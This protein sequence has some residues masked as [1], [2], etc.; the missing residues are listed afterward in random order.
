TGGGAEGL[1]GSFRCPMEGKEDWPAR[2]SVSMVRGHGGLHGRQGGAGIYEGSRTAGPA[3][4]NRLYE[5][6]EP[7]GGRRVSGGYYPRSSYRGC[8]IPRGAGRLV[9]R[10]QPNRYQH[11]SG[12]HLGKSAASQRGA[13]LR[14]FPHIDRRSESFH[15]R[16]FSKLPRGRQATLSENEPGRNQIPRAAGCE[17]QRAHSDLAH[18][19]SGDLSDSSTEIENYPREKLMGYQK[20]LSPSN[21]FIAGAVRISP[22]FP[23]KPFGNDGLLRF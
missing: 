2:R 16:R 8:K 19:I 23:I 3:N 7:F 1:E 12:W 11:S 15:R 22:R 13:T 18:G 21:V 5:H 9:G 10:R 14:R 20:M 17:S 4:T 6:V